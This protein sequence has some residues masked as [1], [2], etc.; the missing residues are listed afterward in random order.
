M[1]NVIANAVKQSGFCV[2]PDCFTP[3]NDVIFFMRLFC[4][5]LLATA[6]ANSPSVIIEGALPDNKYDNE[7]V[8][9]VPVDGTSARTVDSIRIHND[10]FKL[11]ISAHN[12]HKMGFVRVRP[13]LRL[14]LQ[15]I[16]V[17]AEA[18]T[19]QVRLDSISSATGTPLNE[20]LQNWKN[21]RLV[22]DTEVYSI[23]KNTLTANVN[24]SQEIKEA[25]D[26]ATA[27]YYNDIYQ[28]ILDNKENAAGRFIY[29]LHKSFYSPEQIIRIE[30]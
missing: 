28:I 1:D 15:E 19:V 14:A 23:K 22:Y 11:V 4:V 5:L 24:D 12:H 26:N 13:A 7:W 17:L 8:Y 30:N 29:S 9:W 16:I 6:C 25:I 18:G 20:V 27:A 21:R 2:S 3:R 10:S